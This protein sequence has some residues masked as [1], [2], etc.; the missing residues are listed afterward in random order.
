MLCIK[1]TEAFD[2]RVFNP[3]PTY[4]VMYIRPVQY[5]AQYILCIH[6]ICIFTEAIFANSSQTKFVKCSQM[7]Y[8]VGQGWGWGRGEAGIPQGVKYVE[9]WPTTS[10]AWAGCS[11]FDIPVDRYGGVH[12]QLICTSSTLGF[13]T[14]H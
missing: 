7:Q 5:I 2:G 14:C 1:G 11:R 9:S 8:L 6:T 12:S 4:G 10:A 3:Y 13:Y